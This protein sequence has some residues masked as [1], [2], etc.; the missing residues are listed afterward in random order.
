MEIF[1]NKSTATLWLLT[2]L[3]SL[4]YVALAQSNDSDHIKG[5]VIELTPEGEELP[6][7]GANVYWLGTTIGTATNEQGLFGIHPYEGGTQ[8]VISY[9][10]YQSDTVAVVEDKFIKITLSSSVALD[11]VNVVKRRKS[12]EVSYLEARNVQKIGEKELLK[13][14]CCNL[15]ESFE[16]TP[17]IDVSFTDAVTGTRQIQMLGLAG[18]YT[19][20][21]NENMPDVRGLSANYG[22]TYIPG[23]WVEG[24]QLTKGTGSVI[25][26]FESIAGQINVEL[27][28]PQTADKLYLNAYGNEGGRVEG[29]V[30]FKQKVSDKW[31]TGVLLHTSSMGIEQDRNNDGFMDNPTGE[32]FIGLNRWNY[33][34]T[35]KGHEMQIMVKGTKIG[36]DGGEMGDHTHTDHSPWRM[37][38]DAERLEGFVKM[39]KVFAETPWKSVGLQLSG[40]THNM[41]SSYG[42]TNYNARQQS[43]Y[44][45]LLY[46]SMIGNTNHVFITGASMQYDNFDESLNDSTMLREE[47]VSGAFFEYT[48]K[49]GEKFSAVAGV[50]G[51]YHNIF[52]FFA[53]PRL[54]L[55]YAPTEQLVFRA[56]GGRGQRTASIFAENSG[57]FA[58][59]RQIEVLGDGSNKPYGLKPEV[60]WNYGGSITQSFTLDY[61][62]GAVSVE[63]YRT[64]FENQI[65]LD[66]ENPRK[67]VFYNLQGS[68]YSNSFQTQIDYEVLKRVDLRLAYRWYDVHTTYSGQL[69]EKPFVSAN[70]AFANV[71]YETRNN[72][73]FDFTANWQGERRIS[74]TLANPVEYQVA[75]RSPSYFLFNTQIT[76]VWRERFEV[77]VGMENITNYKQKNPILSS[78]QPFSPYFD[79]SLIW[80]PVFGRNTYVGLRYKVF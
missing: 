11:A 46:R 15:S 23:P 12:T 61:R 74:S 55:R 76:K 80:G 27:R 45:N 32:A 13:A 17:G 38:H 36:H 43:L 33:Q 2:L 47:I 30:N 40:V 6:M 72:W 51:D 71:A 37:N 65:V 63:F 69:L 52:G 3:L 22:L 26:G 16:T 8:L 79:S 53:T 44:S 20:I 64:D 59:S 28:K 58:T 50:R 62:D 25:N 56:A 35:E 19:Q 4:N 49:W 29:N 75:E 54:H 7:I 1:S 68:S 66:L 70:R 21:L 60:A 41:K 42:L 78:E 39:G 57:I 18:P 5:Q 10:G 73:K 14:A 9:I 31:S 67:A 48:Y 24:I 77:Y 34:D